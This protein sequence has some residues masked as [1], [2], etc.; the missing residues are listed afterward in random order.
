MTHDHVVTIHAVN[1]EKEVPYLVMEFVAGQSLEKRI[2]INGPLDLKEILRI[3][4]QMASGLAAA[5]SPGTP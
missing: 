5:H 1:E 2:L 4:M 3:G